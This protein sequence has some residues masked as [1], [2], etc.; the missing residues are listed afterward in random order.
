M[1][2]KTIPVFLK[3]QISKPLKKFN[4][5]LLVVGV[6]MIS[7]LVYAV[8]YS[9]VPSINYGASVFSNM[10]T[11]LSEPERPTGVATTSSALQLIIGWTNFVLPY[12]VV[13]A[14]VFLIYGSVLFVT[15]AGSSDKVDQG[16]QIIIWS[17][18]GII[19]ALSSYA[20]VNTIVNF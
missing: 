9:S 12:I 17:V 16:K 18:V 15:S 20:I 7:L 19:L 8:L 11:G 3:H 14:T 1:S 5:L 10:P 2:K 6:A 13:F 4:N